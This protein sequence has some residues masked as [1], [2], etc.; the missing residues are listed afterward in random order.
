MGILQRGPWGG[1]VAWLGFTLPSALALIAFAYAFA[2][3]NV[4]ADDGW[5]HG[6]KIV[7]VAVIA[8]A[9][10]GMGK[11]LC[12]DRARATLAVGVQLPVIHLIARIGV[13]W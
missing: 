8:Q 12:P 7:A 3:L 2:G 6:L 4:T 11:N 13:R 9:I 1:L 10:W 5:L